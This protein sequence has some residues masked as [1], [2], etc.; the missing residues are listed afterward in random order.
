MKK[1]RTGNRRSPGLTP[2]RNNETAI[3]FP[4]LPAISASAGTATINGFRC[5]RPGGH[6]P[7]LLKPKENLTGYRVPGTVKVSG[8]LLGAAE[9]FKIA[10]YAAKGRR[11]KKMGEERPLRR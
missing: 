4:V 9:I 6:Q 3:D 10:R 7:E 1:P 8:D 11:D 5:W 2:V